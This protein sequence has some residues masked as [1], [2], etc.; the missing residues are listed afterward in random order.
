MSGIWSIMKKNFRIMFNSKLSLIILILGPLFLMT[1]TGAALQNTDLRNIKA[2][3]FAHEEGIQHP[4]KKDWFVESYKDQ[5]R[6]ESFAVSETQSL[7]QCQEDVLTSRSHVC[8]EILKKDPINAVQKRIG[9]DINYE[10]KA[11]VDFSK[12]RIV[13]GVIAKT[14]AASEKHTMKLVEG[15]FLEFRNEIDGPMKALKNSKSDLDSAISLLNNVESRLNNVETE[16]HNLRNEVNLVESGFSEIQNRIKSLVSAVHAVEGLDPQIYSLI[17]ELDVKAEALQNDIVDFRTRVNSDYIL[18][19]VDYSREK[20]IEVRSKMVEVRA[21][22]NTVLYE[23]DEIQEFGVDE[24]APLSFT[25]QSVSE[26]GPGGKVGRRLQFLDYLFPSFLMFFIIF[27]SLVF[28]TVTIFRDRSSEAHIRNMT[29]KVGGFSFITGSFFS[30]L[31]V[32][33]L[34]ILIILGVSVFF[35]KASILANIFTL[36]LF[37]F[38][39]L[40]LF[41]LGGIALGYIFNSQEG[42]VIASVAISLLF[43][44]F[45]PGI[46][47]TET[48]PSGFSEVVSIMPF[49]ILEG[50]LRMASIFGVLSGFSIGEVVSMVFAFLIS[51]G[52]V[53]FFY[54]SN[55]H[56]DL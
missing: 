24:L 35:L 20:V 33:F 43:L 6:E 36:M 47:P 30:I 34:Q 13:W 5:L 42:A 38:I 15:L 48:L 37:C 2:S 39:G 3:V 49:V 31:A 40:A 4:L 46:T 29:S 16:V 14:Q 18:K 22:V 51:I 7:S 25:Y 50:K 9:Q 53:S 1:I 56:E 21:D 41:T 19:H 28:S 11:H 55:K 26:N 10:T 27:V 8:I 17:D 32:L 44:I 54:K 52:V 45:L 12:S 23:W